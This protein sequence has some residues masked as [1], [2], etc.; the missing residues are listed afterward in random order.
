MTKKSASQPWGPNFNSSMWHVEQ[1]SLSEPWEWNHIERICRC[2]SPTLYR[3]FKKGKALSHVSYLKITL[4]GMWNTQPLYMLNSMSKSFS[5]S[6]NGMW[7]VKINRKTK[8]TIKR[9][10][11]IYMSFL[12]LF[13]Q[14]FCHDIIVSDPGARSADMKEM[15][16]V[17]TINSSTWLIFNSIFKIF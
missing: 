15:G 3:W 14:W 8:P 5:G 6:N 17:N 9:S 1:V 7:Q 4:K 13:P 10:I 12:V 16:L 11:P 2:L